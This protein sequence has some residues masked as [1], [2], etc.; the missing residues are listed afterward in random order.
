SQEFFRKYALRFIES[1][2]QAIEG[3]CLIASKKRDVAFQKY[4]KELH[5]TIN[6]AIKN[7]S[8]YTTPEKTTKELTS[9]FMSPFLKLSIISKGLSR[10]DNPI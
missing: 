1:K 8:F 3:L 10:P 4:F 9:T 7:M 6:F 5:E 2:M